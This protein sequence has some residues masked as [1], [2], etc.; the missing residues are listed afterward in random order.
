MKID[1]YR[2]K[3]YNSTSKTVVCIDGKPI[4]IVQGCG[5]TLSNIIAYI[6]GYDVKIN[7][8]RIKKIIDEYTAESEELRNE[9]EN[10]MGV[11]SLRH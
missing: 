9:A 7:D 4:C 2:V 5:K 6:H 3:Q 1:T 8:G 11:R 10:I